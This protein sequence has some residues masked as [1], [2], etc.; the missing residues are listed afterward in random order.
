MNSKPSLHKFSSLVRVILVIKIE[1]TS[2][3]KV[4]RLDFH[5]VSKLTLGKDWVV[6]N[7]ST[8]TEKGYVGVFTTTYN[9]FSNVTSRMVPNYVGWSKGHDS[10]SPR[11]IFEICLEGMGLR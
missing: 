5:W 2:Y 9:D 11:D 4:I 8:H 10:L 3:V 6:A 1:F 7:S